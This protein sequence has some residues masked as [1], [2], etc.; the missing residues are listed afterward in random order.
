MQ[1]NSRARGGNYEASAGCYYSQGLG[2][3][4]GIHMRLD[5]LRLIDGDTWGALGAQWNGALKDPLFFYGMAAGVVATSRSGSRPPSNAPGDVTRPPAIEPRGDFSRGETPVRANDVP[6]SNRVN[7]SHTG[8][9]TNANRI[10][11]L[12]LKNGMT[13]TSTH[14]LELGIEFLGKGYSEPKPGSGRYV[15][16]DG[17]RVVRIG[18]NDITGTHA[19]GPHIN[20]EILTLNS[21]T[22]KMTVT[23][24]LHIYIKN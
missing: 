7:V 15:S 17:T 6:S 22:G 14:A 4:D 12:G 18:I 16:A 13:T 10:N 2:S 9:L 20:F 8:P 5:A 3:F 11:S 24:N 21:S 23:Q 19:N 1:P